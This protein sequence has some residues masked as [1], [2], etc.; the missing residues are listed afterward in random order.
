MTEFGE[1]NE[2]Y[3]C[4]ASILKNNLNFP[5]GSTIINNR[6]EAQMLDNKIKFSRGVAWRLRRLFKPDP[7]T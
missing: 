4:I 2:K 1:S 7:L 6:K 5:K 3:P